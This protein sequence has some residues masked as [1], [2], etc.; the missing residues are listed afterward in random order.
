MPRLAPFDSLAGVL[1]PL[2]EPTMSEIDRLMELRKFK[3][4]IENPGLLHTFN[5]S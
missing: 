4:Q 3:E 5:F 1:L 2:F